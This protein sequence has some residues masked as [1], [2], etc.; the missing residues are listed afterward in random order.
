VAQLILHYPKFEILIEQQSDNNLTEGTKS[1][2]KF[3]EKY[4]DSIFQ[5]IIFGK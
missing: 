1:R 5:E 4:V 2:M 3:W